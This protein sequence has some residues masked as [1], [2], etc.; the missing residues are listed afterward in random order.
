[1]LVLFG[2]S[3]NW[4]WDVF[5]VE[6]LLVDLKCYFGLMPIGSDVCL[7]LRTVCEH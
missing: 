6:K 5:D 7:M 3:C 2:H 4:F 1:M